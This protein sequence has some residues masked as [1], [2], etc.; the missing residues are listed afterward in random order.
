MAASRRS[1]WSLGFM[2]L[3]FLA[4]LLSPCFVGQARADEVQEYGTVIGIVSTE[5][6]MHRRVATT[7]METDA[8]Y[9][10]RIWV[11]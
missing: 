7:E 6:A 3:A 4:L 10:S 8:N 5:L 11:L 1:N 9:F 2:L